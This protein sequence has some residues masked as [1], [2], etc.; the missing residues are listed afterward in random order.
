MSTVTAGGKVYERRAWTGGLMI[1]MPKLIPL[2]RVLYR[3]QLKDWWNFWNCRPDYDTRAIFK[4]R[5][6]GDA[7][8]SYRDT[9]HD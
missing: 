9:Y 1:E 6:W 7:Y 4:G 3:E 5:A 2:A 8:A